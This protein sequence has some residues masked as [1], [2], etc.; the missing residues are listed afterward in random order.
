MTDYISF[1]CKLL[2][3]RRLRPAEL[4]LASPPQKGRLARSKSKGRD[5]MATTTKESVTEVVDGDTFWTGES[6]S[7]VRLE[8]VDTPEPHEPGYAAAKEA[9]T[10]L[11]LH[12]E[13]E[14]ETKAH[15]AYGRRVAQVWRLPDYLNVNRALQA[16]G[17]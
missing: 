12:R 11:V 16:Y 13:V 10:R 4:K 2:R 15:D 1:G 8:G 3:S 5:E 7:A 9:L 17:K 14:I 6:P